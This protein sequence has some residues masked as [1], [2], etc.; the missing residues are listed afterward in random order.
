MKVTTTFNVMR[1]MFHSE[2]LASCDL[3]PV[4]IM[5]PRRWTSA[6]AP[7]HDSNMVKQKKQNKNKCLQSFMHVITFILIMV[8]FFLLF[9]RF[10]F[11]FLLFCCVLKNKNIFLY[12]SISPLGLVLKHTHRVWS[13]EAKETNRRVNAKVSV[14]AA[15][16]SE[17]REVVAGL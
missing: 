12:S 13:S 17:N 14:C 11:F 1:C 15:S 10:F 9:I 6:N 3:H 16:S 4:R 5:A 7:P 8:F 2:S